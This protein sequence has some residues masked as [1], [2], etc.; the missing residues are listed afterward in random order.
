[1]KMANAYAE[2]LGCPLGFVAKS[3]RGLD[4]GSDEL[5]WVKLKGGRFY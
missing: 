2:V 4:C 3:A 1:M 5:W